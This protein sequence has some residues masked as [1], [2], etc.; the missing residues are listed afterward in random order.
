MATNSCHFSSDGPKLSSVLTLMPVYVEIWSM[1]EMALFQACMCEFGKRFDK[2]TPIVSLFWLSIF[3]IYPVWIILITKVQ[4]TIKINFQFLIYAD[5]SQIST[6]NFLNLKS[7]EFII[8]LKLMNFAHYGFLF[9]R[10]KQ[11]MREKFMNF[12]DVGSI[13]STIK[14]GKQRARIDQSSRLPLETSSSMRD[15]FEKLESG[16]L[17]THWASL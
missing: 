12:T 9:C 17:L 5:W 6:Y 1:K 4:I 11:R 13:P 16:K 2:F 15:R 3:R 7:V 10:S 14:H 8:P